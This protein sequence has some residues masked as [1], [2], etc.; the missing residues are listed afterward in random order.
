MYKTH[1]HL[2]SIINHALFLP[3]IFFLTQS[4]VFAESNTAQKS[5]RD[6]FLKTISDFKHSGVANRFF[7]TAH[8][9][10]V[11]PTIGKA[12]IGIGGARGKGRVFK[13]GQMIG[14]M[15]MTQLSVGF[16]L[17]AQA[18]SQIVFLQDERALKE[19]TSGNFEFGAGAS[20]IA[21]NASAELKAGS[22][23]ASAS[24]G[25]HSSKTEQA[26]T[27]YYKGMA[28]LTAGKG[29]LMYEASISGQKYQYKQVTEAL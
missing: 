8:A 6:S 20:A 18:Y 14:E 26:E 27:G 11:F 9:Y 29:G 4:P 3:V 23:G 17:G 12:G 5:A 2:R 7:E 21:V 13:G 28:I 24:A 25:L 16:Q 10:A 19:F 22:S 15:T 1:K